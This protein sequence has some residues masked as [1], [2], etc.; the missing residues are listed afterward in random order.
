MKILKINF[1][2][3]PLHCI[4]IS[5]LLFLYKLSKKKMKATRARTTSGEVYLFQN[6]FLIIISKLYSLSVMSYRK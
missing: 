2:F 3:P 5:L 4:A 1:R 6:S